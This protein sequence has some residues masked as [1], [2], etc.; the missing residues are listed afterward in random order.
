MTKKAASSKCKIKPVRSRIFLVLLWIALPSVLLGLAALVLNLWHLPTR[1]Q[2]ELR[3]KSLEFSTSQERPAY[4]LLDFP[5]RFA[6]LEIDGFQH[7][8]FSP[9]H[10]NSLCSDTQRPRVM[11]TLEIYGGAFPRAVLSVD[12]PGQF[13][14]LDIL[15]GT[16]VSVEAGKR[17]LLLKWPDSAQSLNILPD[18][19]LRLHATHARCQSQTARRDADMPWNTEL[20]GAA[21]LLKIQTVA[22][23]SL[24]FELTGSENR[25]GGQSLPVNRIDFS[26]QDDD[27]FQVSTLAGKGKIRYLDYPKLAEAEIEAHELLRIA[28]V[29][30][31]A[32]SLADLKVDSSAG[33]LML[34]VSGSVDR[35]WSGRDY[36]L[37][38]FN[39]LWNDSLG[40]A[41]LTIIVW[42]CTVSVGAY[43]LYREIA[44][45]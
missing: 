33:V 19:K 32:L 40:M 17:Q 2:I 20:S 21:P 25:L 11:Q 9:K 30:D 18:G 16:A 14:A 6:S 3:A 29:T 26:R 41:V 13:S 31:A 15:A 10:P 35:L 42:A 5:L 24:A 27:G 23:G 1:V 38:V 36:R 8:E 45:T 44:G 12:S 7:A 28:S 39:T 34:S 43:K 4:P 22:G 37:T